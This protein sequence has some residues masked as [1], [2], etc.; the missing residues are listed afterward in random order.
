VL[1]RV[2]IE[3]FKAF[4]RYELT[5]GPRV[6]LIGPN[7]AGKSTLVSALRVIAH[8]ARPAQIRRYAR[9]GLGQ[10]GVEVDLQALH[11]PVANLAHKYAEAASEIRG[12]FSED[13]ELRITLRAVGPS[14]GA[15][16]DGWGDPLRGEAVTGALK[17]SVG[18]V[19]PVGPLELE[20]AP[21][22]EK[23]V[24]AQLEGPLSPRHFRNQWL[25]LP[26][27]WETFREAI[28]GTLA[29]IDIYRPEVHMGGPKGR[30]MMLFREGDWVGEVGWA[31]HGLQVWLQIVTHLMRL[32]G[33]T[34]VI[35]DEPDIYLHPDLQRRVVEQ[36]NSLGLEQFI[37]ASHSV[38]ILDKFTPEDVVFV[39]KG[40]RRGRV[41]GGLEDVQRVISDLG[42][43][44]NIHAARLA[45]SRVCL[46][47]EGGDFEI[48][49]RMAGV[50]GLKEFAEGEGFAVVPIEG[51]GNWERLLH[52][53][54]VMRNVAGEAI[55]PYVVLDRDYRCDD[56]VDSIVDSLGE[57]GVRCHVWRRKELENY[58]LVPGAIARA[59]NPCE[60]KYAVS[61]AR[62]EELLRRCADERG[63]HVVAQKQAEAFRWR[64]R[65][66]MSQ[67]T[68]NQQVLE[69]IG[70]SWDHQCLSL[71]GGKDLLTA[72]RRGLEELGIHPPSNSAILACMKAEDVDSEIVDA[73]RRVGHAA[74]SQ[75][76]RGRPSGAWHILPPPP[77]APS[78]R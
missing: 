45:R 40:T 34:C 11:I 69:E 37:V 23:Y 8:L 15:W 2:E 4:E 18:V 60:G 28:R 70:A 5:L 75:A 57:K 12:F 22:S 25:Y 10:G 48:L 31:G 16:F 41:L 77:G 49:R 55:R 32:R 44:A 9:T 71:V 13:L 46:F 56:E 63:V 65:D 64:K 61:E 3:N 27:D 33:R 6:L 21:L 62:I 76:R 14:F 72:M 24:R 50:A 35:L 7:N 19:P 51:F 39:D 52:V 29:D 36:V 58:L 74:R 53:S 38:D 30:V 78:R 42:S 54:W 59:V 20:E 26:D 47:V 68:V 1:E 43:T 67:A 73:C 66:G 17:T